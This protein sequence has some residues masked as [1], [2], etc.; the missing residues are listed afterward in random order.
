MNGKRILTVQDLSCVGQCSLTVAL[1]VLSH[2]GVE[3]AVLPTAVLSNHTMF[4]SW[5]YLDLTA[6][7]P[8]IYENWKKNG[9]TFSGFLLGYL[10]KSSI[11]DLCRTAFDKFSEAG[12]PVIIDPAFGDNGKLYGGFDGEYVAAML[13][14]LKRADIIL[15]NITE[16]SYLLGEQYKTQ[17]DKSYVEG[18]AERLR[19]A[20]GATVVITGVEQDGLIGE[21]IFDGGKPEYVLQ[22]KVPKFSH[23]TGDIFAAAFTARY[24]N[25][26][27]LASACAEA[28]KLVADCL[29]ATADWHGYGVQFEDVLFSQIKK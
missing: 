8:A 2:Y 15:P 20:T 14:L 12:A 17:Y 26:D 3:A 23:G 19:A 25:G 28:G 13:S 24:L 21:L 22:E 11:M 9:I 7:I 5:S 4:K 10:G 1:P 6:E 29:R 16:A 27:S 18:M